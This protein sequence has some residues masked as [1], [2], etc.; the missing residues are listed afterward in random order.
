VGKLAFIGK[1]VRGRFSV[2]F[3][4]AIDN[5]IVLHGGEGTERAEGRGQRAE[6]RRARER[7]EGRTQKESV[8]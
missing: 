4:S 5:Q 8:A 3:H 2:S 6:G 1:S 7:V